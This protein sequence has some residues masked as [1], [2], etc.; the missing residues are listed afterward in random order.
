MRSH[1]EA[2]SEWL[3]S[4]NRLDREAFLALLAPEFVAKGVMAP[5]G[6]GAEAI[7]DF[8]VA[9]RET[10]P[11]QRWELGRWLVADRDLVVCE[12]VENGTFA[13]PWPDPGRAIP[14]TNRS[15]ESRAVMLFRFNPDGL[16][17][18]NESWYDS[19]DWFHQIGVDPNVAAPPNEV[20]DVTAVLSAR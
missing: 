10:F 8:M 2:A 12:V 13:G 18:E 11:D 19:V 15:Y 6:I 9:F 17:V 7:W 16:I 3:A 1:A 14:P 4:W 20:P 5:Q